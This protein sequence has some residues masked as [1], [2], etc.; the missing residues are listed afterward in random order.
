M[1]KRVKKPE[2]KDEDKEYTCIRNFNIGCYK[3]GSFKIIGKIGE[4]IKLSKIKADAY[5][6]LKYI[7]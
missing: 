5:K 6:H 7:K 4:K 2:I 1:E 3:N